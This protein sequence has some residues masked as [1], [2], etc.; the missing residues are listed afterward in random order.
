[1]SAVGT[2]MRRLRLWLE[3]GFAP[4]PVLTAIGLAIALAGAVAGPL[5]LVGAGRVV[6]GLTSS[7]PD[8]V[9][10]GL[11]L[12]AVGI[13]VGALQ[14]VSFPLVWFFAEDLGERYGKH[15]IMT[16]VAGI[17]TLTHHE[18]PA[19]ADRVALL[20]DK[21]RHLGTAGQSISYHASTIVRLVTIGGVLASIDW[22]LALLIPA[23][24]VPAW[25]GGRQAH[26]RYDAETENAHAVRTADRLLDIARSP[27]NGIEIR[28]SG[29]QSALLDA[30]DA[31][32]G[33]RLDKVVAASRQHRA[34]TT[35]S[36]LLWIALL[37]ASLV[38]VLALVRDGV[39][40]VGSILVLVLLVAQIEDVVHGLT[41]AVR[42]AVNTAA[43]ME[44]LDAVT[45]YAASMSGGER[46]LPAPAAL[47]RGIELR[48]VSFTYPSSDTMAVR[49]LTLH[50][51]PGSTVA[52]V[53]ENGAGKSTLVKL[54]A[55]LYEPTRG[56]ILVDGT[57]LHHFAPRAWPSRVSAVFQDHADFEF[58]ARESVGVGDLATPGEVTLLRALDRADASGFMS[59]LPQGLDAQLGRQFAGGTELSGGQWQRLAIARGFMR[60]APVL[61]LL[62]EPS[63]ALD[64]QAEDTI[65]VGYLRRAK[66]MARTTGGITVIVSHRMS[67]VRAA[68]R[69]LHLHE[70]EVVEDG[71]HD[72]L[73]AHGGLYAELFELQAR[74]YR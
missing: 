30:Q 38:W 8:L 55:G 45:S 14:V 3:F 61:M 62:D 42:Y 23:A 33:A 37:G 44:Q 9:S 54:F 18:M 25:A 19:M 65:L 43:Q 71:T 7:R 58:L 21:A 59:T 73:M 35:G 68:D 31:A 64:A 22:W 41:R 11:W 16:L 32:L 5:A 67:T 57:P 10:S 24:M 13:V 15:R 4:A 56:A 28:C 52:L 29:A 39:Q 74:S 70:G 27:D 51:A 17:P 69:V 50:I 53:G 20:R 49:D 48:D 63:S 72:E 47:L 26:A 2:L 40:P 12:V 36:R 66:E 1:M 46:T 60:E 6:D 34:T